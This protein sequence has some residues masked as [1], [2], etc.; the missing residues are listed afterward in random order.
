M[1]GQNATFD[2]LRSSLV[3]AQVASVRNDLA[4]LNADVWI[5]DGMKGAKC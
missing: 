1:S 5:K 2:V 4:G 3:P